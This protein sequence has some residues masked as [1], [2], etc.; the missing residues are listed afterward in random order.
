MKKYLW[1][2]LLMVLGILSG[3]THAAIINVWGDKSSD[4]FDA[5][6][7]PD[8]LVDAL[9]KNQELLLPDNFPTSKQVGFNEK[10]TLKLDNDLSFGG[11]VFAKGTVVSS[12]IIYFDTRDSLYGEHSNVNWQFDGD[13]LAVLT[14]NKDLKATDSLFGLSGNTYSFKWRGLEGSDSYS[15]EGDTLTLSM[16]VSEPGDWVRVLVDVP[17]PATVALL[18]VG[19]LMLGGRSMLNRRCPARLV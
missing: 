1:I 18:G 15:F 16:V 17:E 4:G 6:F 11:S 2:P 10:Q 14:T 8:T 3:T 19:L 12:H 5:R 13:I 7:I 9:Y